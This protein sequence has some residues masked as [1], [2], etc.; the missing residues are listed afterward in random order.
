MNGKVK[1]LLII[2]AVLIYVISPVDLLPGIP[3][4]DII[5]GLLGLV[6][7]LRNNRLNQGRNGE[8]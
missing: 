2:L 6:S 5:V 7:V 3:V 8:D 1:N 4:D